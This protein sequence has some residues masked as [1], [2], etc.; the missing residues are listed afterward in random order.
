MLCCAL[1]HVRPPFFSPTTPKEII[2]HE[3]INFN[4]CIFQL[5]S[6][7]P[8]GTENVPISMAPFSHH[9]EYTVQSMPATSA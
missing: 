8:Q 2:S 9:A 5:Y 1:R 3:F 7:P 6:Y 4:F